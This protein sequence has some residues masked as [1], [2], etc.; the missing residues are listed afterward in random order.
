MTQPYL[1]QKSS[2]GLTPKSTNISLD[3]YQT[4]AGEELIRSTDLEDI[5]VLDQSDYAGGSKV[6]TL[7]NSFITKYEKLAITVPTTSL[8]GTA[9]EGLDIVVKVVPSQKIYILSSPAK[10]TIPLKNIKAF[11]S[12][13]TI[14]TKNIDLVIKGNVNYNGMFLVKDGTIAFEKS[15]EVV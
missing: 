1:A 7:M 15:D 11:T 6:Q 13:F 4:L 9:F 3:G 5:M 2:F 10:K 12:P 14:V 8:T